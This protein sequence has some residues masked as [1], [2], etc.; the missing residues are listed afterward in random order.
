[1]T[2]Y[3]DPS[4]RLMINVC[5]H[6]LCEACVGLMFLRESAQCW[7]CNRTLKR[8]DFRLQLFED[9]NVEKEVGIRKSV[10]KIYNKLPEDFPDLRSYNDYQENIEDMIWGLE[11]NLDTKAI[12]DQIEEYK[13]E[14]EALIR[15]NQLKRNKEREKIREQ[16]ETSKAE[17]DKNR[18]HYKEVDNSSIA[19]H[20]KLNDEIIENLTKDYLDHEA[21]MELQSRYQMGSENERNF[22]DHY[23]GKDQVLEDMDVSDEPY[24]YQDLIFDFFGPSLPDDN[25]FKRLGYLNNIRESNISALAGGYNSEIACKRALQDAFSGLLSTPSSLAR[26]FG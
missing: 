3:R 22:T 15:K 6:A 4:L 12:R 10:L 2:K 8:K 23:D 25:T 24:Q 17:H 19:D 7:E 13:Q 21:I 18:K 5:G 20:Q 1:M 11:N 9:A 26:S 16:I 14:N